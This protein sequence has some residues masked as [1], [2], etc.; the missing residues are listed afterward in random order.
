MICSQLQFTTGRDEAVVPRNLGRRRGTEIRPEQSAQFLH[1][2]GLR[3]ILVFER[4]AVG[5]VGLFD[6][7]A[8]GVE[9]PTVIRAAYAVSLRDAVGERGL[10]MRAEL[11]DQAEVSRAALVED[12][13][14]AE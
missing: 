2:I 5:F 6:A 10:A 9:L 12:E 8:G 11:G 14:F 3:R 7:R 4:A 13:I 1:R